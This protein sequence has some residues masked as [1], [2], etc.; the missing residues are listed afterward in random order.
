MIGALLG[1]FV[2]PIGRAALRYGAPNA[3]KLRRKPT[4]P[5]AGGWKPQLAALAVVTSLFGACA[6]VGS[7]PKATAG[8]PPV[9]E[10]GQE[11]HARVADKLALLP[12]GS[13]VVETLSNYSVMRS[14]R[15]FSMAIGQTRLPEVIKAG[16]RHRIHTIFA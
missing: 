6:T 7:E 10:Y 8:C 9:V 4:K 11:F 5:N 15:G 2:G 13:V 12:E 14:R 3:L 16:A 1:W